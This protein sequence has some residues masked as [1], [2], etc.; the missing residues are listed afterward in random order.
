[1]TTKTALITGAS[2]GIGRALARVFAEEGY[3]V[4]LVARRPE[5]LELLREEIEA[6]GG[7]AHVAVAD[8][9][10]RRQVHAAV[11]AV[12]DALGPVHLVVANAGVSVDTDPF[13]PDGKAFE[14][15]V[16]VNLQGAW[17]A[18]EATVPGMRERRSG[19]IVA[20]SSVAAWLPIPGSA[21]YTATKAGLSAMIESFR[22]DWIQE[23]IRATLVHPGFVR[24][25]MTE[26][27][28]F[29]KPFLM[30]ADRA[31][32]IIARAVRKG[33]K[34]C[35]FPLRMV[36]LVRFL[37]LLPDGVLRWLE[38]RIRKDRRERAG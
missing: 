15:E 11:K 32:R 16:E 27:R 24:S 6:A 20:V 2:S 21:G 18:I 14:Y 23:G 30:D 37:R 34:Q 5:L 26:G 8:V 31:A 1:M 25:Q 35:N 36:L 22:H 38:R 17:Y 9:R 4:G 33:R 3:A 28:D 12:A 10:S 7:R 13:A 29:P 19:H